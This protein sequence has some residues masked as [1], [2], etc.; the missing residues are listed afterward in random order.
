MKEGLA[1]NRLVF[2][3]ML[4]DFKKEQSYYEHKDMNHPLEDFINMNKGSSSCTF[5]AR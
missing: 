5:F 4:F 3:G 1:T 2:K